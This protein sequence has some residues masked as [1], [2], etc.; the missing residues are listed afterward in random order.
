MA[1][2]SPR[3]RLC[4][5]RRRSLARQCQRAP[6][7]LS[8]TCQAP[9]RRQ[10]I[11]RQAN[12]EGSQP[13]T[14]RPE[15]RE[16]S[17][18]FEKRR[19]RSLSPAQA[20]HPSSSQGTASRLFAMSRQ[21]TPVSLHPTQG[22][23]G[24]GRAW[25][26]TV[27]APAALT[28]VPVCRVAPGSCAEL[29]SAPPPRTPVLAHTLV[30]GG[31]SGGEGRGGCVRDPCCGQPSASG[32]PEPALPARADSLPEPGRARSVRGPVAAAGR[33]TGALGQLPPPRPRTRNSLLLL[34]KN[35]SEHV[36]IEPH[37]LPARA[38]TIHEESEPALGKWG[39]QDCGA[40]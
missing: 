17:V 29:H 16:R 14:R 30:L 6:Q 24:R 38:F 31:A 15:K 28:W 33:P 8:R 4:G 13:E 26:R 12:E 25:C 10:G 35:P 18:G 2:W 39:H 7:L 5:I 20:S 27:C 34:L 1:L 23:S 21:N 40:K 36:Y 37:K 3:A 9:R 19:G 22:P 11:Y 32:P